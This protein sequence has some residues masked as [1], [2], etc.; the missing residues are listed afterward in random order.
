MPDQSP[1]AVKGHAPSPDEQTRQA[2][3]QEVRDAALLLEFAVSQGRVLEVALIPL[4]KKSQGFLSDGVP[5]PSDQDRSEFEAAY[6]DLAQAMKPVTAATLRATLDAPWKPSRA[7][8][9]SKQL[10]VWV[11][12][13]AAIIIG[14]QVLPIMC[15]PAAPP[16][17]PSGSQAL[18]PLGLGAQTPVVPAPAAQ[19]STALAPTPLGP[20]AQTPAALAPAAQPSVT[21]SLTPPAPGAQVPKVRAETAPIPRVLAT[22]K[23]PQQV[24]RDVTQTFLPFVF[25]LLGAVT[26]L[27]RSAHT[28]IAERTFDLN[29]RPEYYNRM[30]LGFLGGGIALLLVPPSTASEIAPS[31]VL[32]STAKVGQNAVSFFVGYNTDYL[33]QMIERV[34]QAVFPKESKA[35]AAA[36]VLAGISLA[37]EKLSVGDA[38]SATIS[39]TGVAPAGGLLVTLIADDGI[40]LTAKIVKI[41]EGANSAPFTFKVKGGSN[42]TAGTKLHIT[43]KQD[44]SS[45]IA[46]VTVE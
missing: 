10:Y 3:S 6:R 40:E 36:A 44:S 35:A 32:P 2:F 8:Q 39:V 27:L 11:F 37:R 46:T 7:R 19:P 4:I 23:T 26:F 34:A 16:V 30:V 14:D 9:F 5:W 22:E 20:G 15:P 29:R 1:T 31:F 25:G 24:V 18:T 13:C 33:F 45:M 12:L 43:A 41:P 21:Q 38:G 42:I 17:Q 28:Y